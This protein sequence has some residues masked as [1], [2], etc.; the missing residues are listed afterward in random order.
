MWRK[1][2]SWLPVFLCILG[3]TS[4]FVNGGPLSRHP[5]H[6]SA[7]GSRTITPGAYTM[8]HG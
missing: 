4:V 2:I 1:P 7:T 6:A 3:L 5:D 8:M